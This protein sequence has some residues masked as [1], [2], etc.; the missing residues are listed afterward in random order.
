MQCNALPEQGRSRAD[1]T[2]SP[3]SSSLRVWHRAQQTPGR[4]IG[5]RHSGCWTDSG[6]RAP[7]G[8]HRDCPRGCSRSKMIVADGT[9]PETPYRRP[10]QVL[11]PCGM[12]C[13]RIDTIRHTSVPT[14]GHLLYTI[15]A[16]S[17]MRNLESN[18][19]SVCL[20]ILGAITWQGT[21]K[22]RVA[23]LVR[24]PR[25]TRSVEITLASSLP[26]RRGTTAPRAHHQNNVPAFL[27]FFSWLRSC[28][29]VLAQ[30]STLIS[31]FHP[32]DSSSTDG[33]ATATHRAT[34][35]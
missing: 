11:V 35:S 7:L 16:R 25:S 6:P 21:A 15:T 23:R 14:S 31:E 26:W 2:S 27:Q 4:H 12:G 8:G 29:R 13:S 5:R 9:A 18:W 10:C 3:F 22:A 30:S 32:R 20:R 34:M 33:L 1:I 28:S 19:M 24:F 17:A